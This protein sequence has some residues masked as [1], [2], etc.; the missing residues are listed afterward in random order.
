[1]NLR[2]VNRVLAG[3]LASLALG[4]SVAAQGVKLDP[5]QQK[6]TA[7]SNVRARGGPETSAAEVTRLKL[8]TV[9][10]A[11]ARTAEEAEI[12]G[13]RGHWYLVS[14]PSGG[15][16]WVF[17]GLLADYDAARRSEIARR[18][19]ADRLSAETMSFD[20][21]TDLYNFASAAAAEAK[22]A[23]ERAG[24]ELAMLRALDRSVLAVPYDQREKAPY[25]DWLKAHDKEI[26][27]HEFSGNFQVASEAI[28]ELEKK[29]RGT[30]SGE[31]IAWA[32]AQNPIPSDCESDEVC[33]FLYLADTDG[34]Y[35]S[36]YPTGAHAAQAV[37]GLQR[38]LE[39]EQLKETL[40]A[41][42]PDQYVMQYQKSLRKALTDLRA[43]VSKSSLP[44]KADILKRINQL[45]PAGR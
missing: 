41:K 44:A 15:T 25:R 30:P 20:E 42:K 10:T 32:A 9:L 34:R 39:S 26:V 6:I 17:G 12:G 33:A 18:I 43:A 16:A 5:A 29:Y 23:E 37:E 7:A 8:G 45:M 19:V 1:M 14:L 35:L 24:F 3:L 28:W 4:A 11:T 36:L 27:Y 21:G 31:E 40:G 38:A 2:N 13:R 22:S